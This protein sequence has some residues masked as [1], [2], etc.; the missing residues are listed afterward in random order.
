MIYQ[1]TEK[2]KVVRERLRTAQSRQK[3]YTYVSVREL[4]FKVSDWVFSR[5]LLRKES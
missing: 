5:Y 4:K 2:V 3:S 1:A